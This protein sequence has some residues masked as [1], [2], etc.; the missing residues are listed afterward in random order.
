MVPAIEDAPLIVQL[1]SDL[2]LREIAEKF[3]TTPRTIS[4]ILKENKVVVKKKGMHKNIAALLTGSVKYTI[5]DIASIADC[6][7]DYVKSVKKRMGLT[8]EATK[9]LEAVDF[10]PVRLIQSMIALGD[11][12]IPE[13]CA[14]VGITVNTY[15]YRKRIMREK[16]AASFN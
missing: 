1:Y 10:K 16:K 4:R 12:S 14:K 6:S 13:A 11:H 2:S 9:R 5:N 8:R 3:D 7:P 15:Y